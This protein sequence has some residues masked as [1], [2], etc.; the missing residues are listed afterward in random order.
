[1]SNKF[2][3]IDDLITITTLSK[4]TINRLI[5]NDEFPKP[6]K[7]GRLALWGNDQINDWVNNKL[8][9]LKV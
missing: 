7:I 8:T 1:M 4:S 5:K 3:K 2:L 6:T 9:T